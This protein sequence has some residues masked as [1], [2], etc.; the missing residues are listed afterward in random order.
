MAKLL[1]KSRDGQLQAFHLKL[2]LNRIGRDSACDFQIDDASVSSRHCEVLLADGTLLLRDCSSTNGTY[3]DE[4]MVSESVVESGQTI[5]IGRVKMLV[6]ISQA[7]VAIPDLPAPKKAEPV[8]LNDGS[9]SCLNHPD[10]RAVGKCTQCARIFCLPCIHSVKRVG[11]RQWKLCPVCSGHCVPLS[12]SE[13]KKKSV[14]KRTLEKIKRGL[15][16][17]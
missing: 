5:R 12:G 7:N 17:R 3:L 2:G 6:E 13:R 16:A 15:L 14:L 10:R 11:G 1:I 8:A 4:E 9:L